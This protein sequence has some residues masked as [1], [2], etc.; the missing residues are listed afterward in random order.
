MIVHWWQPAGRP[1]PD[2]A[3]VQIFITNRAKQIP[4]IGRLLFPLQIRAP[5]NISLLCNPKLVNARKITGSS[6]IGYVS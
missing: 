5:Y 1:W 6:T 4:H 2:Y 3:L